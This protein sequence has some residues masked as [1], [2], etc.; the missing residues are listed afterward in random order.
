VLLPPADQIQAAIRIGCAAVWRTSPVVRAST[1]ASPP[2]AIAG[3]VPTLP[4]S[5]IVAER[6]AV[7]QL[8]RG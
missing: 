8:G 4:A 2:A 7:N 3:D 1:V 6:R 5:R